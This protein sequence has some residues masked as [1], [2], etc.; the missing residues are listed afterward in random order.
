MGSSAYVL[1]SGGGDS[2]GRVRQAAALWRAGKVEK[3][4]V[5]GDHGSWIYDEPDTMR[6][7]GQ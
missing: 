6:N 3:V 2:T 1:L 7:A 4:L 5:S